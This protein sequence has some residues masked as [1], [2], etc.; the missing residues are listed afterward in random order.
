M[1]WT[2]RLLLLVFI[3]AAMGC[4]T[5]VVMEDASI[6]DATPG[7]LD[8]P[9]ADVPVFDAASLP[10]AAPPMCAPTTRPTGVIE[11]VGSL[12]AGEVTP[13]A[14][15]D[16]CAA[17]AEA[18]CATGCGCETSGCSDAAR[19]SCE[20][21]EGPLNPRTMEA[22]ER[23]EVTYDALAAARAIAGIAAAAR[24]CAHQPRMNLADILAA[25]GTLH[26]EPRPS[27]P[28][29]WCD[30]METWSCAAG[31]RCVNTGDFVFACEVS[32]AATDGACDAFGLCPRPYNTEL[33]CAGAT[34]DLGAAP[35][36]QC[37][38]RACASDGCRADYCTCP[39]E[40]GAACTNDQ[41]CA[42]GHCRGGTCSSAPLST[43]G[44]PCTGFNGCREGV[45][46]GGTCVTRECGGPVW[47]P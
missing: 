31:S 13:I 39:L 14:A 26:A 30:P 16:L 12:G 32:P 29:R 22:I 33:R 41:T 28:D 38:N 18:V 17:F 43:L 44:G 35:G 25:T 42:T 24:D 40:L 36:E 6:P 46:S 10:D 7:P 3:V 34:C 23:G 4:E 20:G 45:C 37:R 47:W 27:R 19:R 9:L 1:G 5:T 11:V 8:A 21:V 15:V 2:W